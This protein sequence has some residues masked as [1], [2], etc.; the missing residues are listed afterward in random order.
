M[1]GLN[2]QKLGHY[3]APTKEAI[4]VSCLNQMMVQMMDVMKAAYRNTMME[5]LMEN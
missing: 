3:L 5:G 2:A 4:L 1:E